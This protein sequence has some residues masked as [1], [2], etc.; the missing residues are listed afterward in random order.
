MFFCVTRRGFLG[1]GFLNGSSESAAAA[2]RRCRSPARAFPRLGP[3]EHTFC[4]LQPPPSVTQPEQQHTNNSFCCFRQAP[5][6]MPSAACTERTSKLKSGFVFFS[7][8]KKA[9]NPAIKAI[10]DTF[11]FENKQRSEI[12]SQYFSITSTSL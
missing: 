9:L 7:C 12:F 3:G 5:V 8:G 2:C 6:C 11:V 10:S 4:S 1:I